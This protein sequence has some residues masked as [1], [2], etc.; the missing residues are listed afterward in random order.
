MGDRYE[1]DV[2]FDFCRRRLCHAATGGNDCKVSASRDEGMERV[3]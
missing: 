2:D 1:S 3:S